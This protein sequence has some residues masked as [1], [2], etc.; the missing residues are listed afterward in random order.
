MKTHRLFCAAVALYAAV[1]C[2]GTLTVK[3]GSA[4]EVEID[5]VVQ[6]FDKNATFAPTNI[7]CIYKMRPANLAEG[8]RTFAIEGTETIRGSDVYRRFPQYGDGNWVRVGLDLYPASDTTVT[9]TGYK[10]SNFYYVDATNGDDDWDG[11]T[12]AIPTQEVIDA[13][14]P[15]PGPKKSLQAMHDAVTG[16]YPVIFA[17]PGVYN[18]GVATNYSSGTSNPCIRRLIATKKNIGFIATE[19]ADKTFIVGAPDTSGTDGKFGAE[20]ISG[21]FMDSNYPQFIQGFTITGCYSPGTQGSV[22]VRQGTAFNSVARRAYCL[23]CVISNN[24]AVEKSPAVKYAVALRTRI[25]ENESYQFTT[26]DGVFVS[27]IFARNRLTIGNLK[28]ISNA[29]HDGSYTY[30]CTYDLK[31]TRNTDGRKQLHNNS[32]YLYAALAYGLTDKTSTNATYWLCKSQA[33]DNPKFVNIS[34]RDYRLASD[35]PAIDVLSYKDDLN[36]KCRMLMDFR[37]TYGSLR[38][39][40]VKI[41]LGAAEYDWR[42]AFA[43]AV[44]KK[45]TLTDVSLSV[46]T[47]A[48]GGL[49]IGGGEGLPALPY[50]AG[51]FSSAGKYELVLSLTGGGLAVYAGDTLVGEFSGTGEQK[52][53][54]RISDAA[55]EVRFVFTP[56][57]ENPGAAVLKQ[58]ASARGFVMDFK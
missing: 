12:A 15:I 8:E 19:G 6:S 51:T 7:P 14:K 45:L 58:L 16:D 30:F 13:G 40:N 3:F 36:G 21:V 53:V 48:A 25:M 33:I 54:F 18:T 28:N 37:D 39:L 20:S 46:T 11:S 34:A 47:N 31:N 35:S 2:G 10:T 52:M 32:T 50:V 56:D 43:H 22:N 5:G 41:D 23:D 29:I 38:A 4:M 42:P 49:V 55:D 27:C 1:S 9:L 26:A 44:G 57:A 24:Y 17:A